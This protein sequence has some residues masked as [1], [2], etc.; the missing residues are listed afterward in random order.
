[1]T[2][3]LPVDLYRPLDFDQTQ[4]F[5]EFLDLKDEQKRMYEGVEY[6]CEDFENLIDMHQWMVDKHVDGIL[7]L[8]HLRH[9]KFLR[10]YLDTDL[11]LACS[12]CHH[13]IHRYKECSYL[14]APKV[15]GGPSLSNLLTLYQFDDDF[16]VTIQS[17]GP[18]LVPELDT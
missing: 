1:M 5:H 17:H 3:Q 8:M 10:H 15:R 16:I 2:T 12:F 6:N 14:A 7:T 4:S 13:L 9:I 11:I 18:R